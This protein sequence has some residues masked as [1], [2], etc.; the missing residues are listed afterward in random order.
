MQRGSARPQWM[1][2]ADFLLALMKFK[3]R[4]RRA[5]SR[6]DLAIIDCRLQ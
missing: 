4:V 3:A 5:L 2:L 1:H 6:V